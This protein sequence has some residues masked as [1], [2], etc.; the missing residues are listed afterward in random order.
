[1]ATVTATLINVVINMITVA[2]HVKENPQKGFTP[3]GALW[4]LW[5]YMT[6]LFSMTLYI[7]LSP[8]NMMEYHPQLVMWATGILQC[9]LIMHMMLAHL[10]DCQFNLMRKTLIP[11]FI[12]GIHASIQCV[13]GILSEPYCIQP[14]AE[15]KTIVIGLAILVFV[16]YLHMVVHLVREITTVLNIACFT[17]PHAK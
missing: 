7:Y 4:Q 17:I 8:A 15:E 6:L 12:I 16:T 5:P 9:K 14:L 1:M 2:K 11:I 13:T 10:C 3:A